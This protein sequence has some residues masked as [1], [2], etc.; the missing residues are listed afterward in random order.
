MQSKAM[1]V[2]EYMNELSEERKESI[3]KLRKTLLDNIPKGFEECMNYG[4]IGYVV[5][6]KI[7][8]SG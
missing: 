3:L 2:N 5:P 8:P 6:H 1:T 4:M 7:Y